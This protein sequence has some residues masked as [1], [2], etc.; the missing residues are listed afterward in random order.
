[1][2]KIGLA[3]KRIRDEKAKTAAIKRYV[4]G[5]QDHLV[6]FKQID[7][8]IRTLGDSSNVNEEMSRQFEFMRVEVDNLQKR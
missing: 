3:R 7:R 5:I 1:M 6:K 8:D 4:K 2:G